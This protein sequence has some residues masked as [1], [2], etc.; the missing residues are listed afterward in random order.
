MLFQY[1]NVKS[2]SDGKMANGYRFRALE[3]SIH[4]PAHRQ[5]GVMVAVSP[6]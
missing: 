5:F 1:I 4:G 3:V 6:I 2:S